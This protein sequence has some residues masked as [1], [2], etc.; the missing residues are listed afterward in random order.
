MA[1]RTL[2]VKF[3]VVGFKEAANSIEQLKKGINDG[4]KANRQATNT[5]IADSQKLAKEEVE[6]GK[7]IARTSQESVSLPVF[8]CIMLSLKLIISKTK[9]AGK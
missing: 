2:G 1:T 9:K 6:A 4:L 5:A 7:K 8:V 3:E